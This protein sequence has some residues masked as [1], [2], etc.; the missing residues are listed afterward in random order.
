M[1]KSRPFVFCCGCILGAALSFIGLYFFRS[2]SAFR[3]AVSIF[4]I[5][6]AASVLLMHLLQLSGELEDDIKPWLRKKFSAKGRK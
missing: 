1:K 4:V 3:V 5:A 6:G 2:V